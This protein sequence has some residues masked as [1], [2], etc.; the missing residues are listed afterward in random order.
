MVRGDDVGQ[1]GAR[2][3]LGVQKPRRWIAFSPACGTMAKKSRLRRPSFGIVFGEADPPA[4]SDFQVFTPDVI[5]SGAGQHGR[6]RTERSEITFRGELRWRSPWDEIWQT[7]PIGSKDAKNIS[8]FH[9][10]CFLLQAMEIPTPRFKAN[11]RVVALLGLTLSPASLLA[12]ETPEGPAD[13]NV[14]ALLEKLHPLFDY[15]IA[16]CAKFGWARLVFYFVITV[17]LNSLILLGISRWLAKKEGTLKNAAF[18]LLLRWLA[19]VLF[20]AGVYEC[21]VTEFWVGIPVLGLALTVAGFMIPMKLYRIGFLRAL[22]F[23]LCYGISSM[24]AAPIESFIAEKIVAGGQPL[25]W[26]VVAALS[27]AQRQAILDGSAA[28]MQD[29]GKI[30]YMSGT[31][32]ATPAPAAASPA[33]PTPGPVNIVAMHDRLQAERDKLNTTDAAAV[34]L[35]NQHAAEYSAANARLAATLAAANAQAATPVPKKTVAAV[36]TKKK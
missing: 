23:V 15:F 32:P 12:A 6:S 33:A 1:R 22:A 11:W 27:P 8:A 36:S 17:L 28:K 26:K 34:A 4:L 20:A 35:F 16:Q 31:A 9:D 2:F 3:D 21:I 13:L 10:I 14:R 25:P 18:Y 24:I 19:F 29:S 7:P 5:G 30:I